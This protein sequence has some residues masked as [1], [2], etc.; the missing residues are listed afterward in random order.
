MAFVSS[1][2]A[3]GEAEVFE[4][5]GGFIGHLECTEFIVPRHARTTGS[6][7]FG[8]APGAMQGGQ[9]AEFQVAI[10]GLCCIL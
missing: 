1:V 3:G 9:P 5:F 10:P 4:E 2:S 6:Q 7:L 8:A